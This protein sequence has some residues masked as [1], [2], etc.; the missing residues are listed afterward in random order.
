MIRK[1]ILSSFIFLFLISFTTVAQDIIKGKVNNYDGSEPIFG[2]SVTIKDQGIGTQT[3]ENGT[4]SFKYSGEYPFELC[5]CYLGFE[6]KTISISSTD[7]SI[8]VNLQEESESLDQVVVTASKVAESIVQAPVTIEKIGLAELRTTASVDAYGALYNLKGVQ[9]NTGSLTFTSINTRGFADMNNVRFVQLLDGMDSSAPGL[10]FPLGSNSGPADI[11]IASMELVPG[12]NSALYGANAF[13]GLIS[14]KTKNPFTYQGLSAYGKF[15]VTVQDAGG[16]NPLYDFGVRYAHAFNDKWAFKVNFG[17][18]TATDW[19]ANDESYHI[20][21]DK[22]SIKD[23]LLALPRNNPN[24]NAVNVYG[25]ELVATVDLDGDGTPETPINRTGINEEDIIDYDI[26]SYKFDAGIYY[27]IKDDMQLSYDYRYIQ[28]DGIYRHTTMYPLMNWE[29]QF[30]RLALESSSLN[31]LAFHSMEDAADSYAMLNT[32]AY[33]EGR[34]RSNAEWGADYGEAFRSG[35]SHDA[36]REYADSFMPAI[37]SDQYNQYLDETLSNTDFSTG[38]SKFDDTSTLSSIEGNY[39]FN[40]E[41]D[42]MELQIG[43]NYRL[44]QLNSSG[45]LFNDGPLGFDDNIDIDEYG[46]YAQAGKKIFNDRLH[47]RGSLRYDK[48]KNFDG[49]VTPRISAVFSFDEEKNHNLRMSYQTG[50]RNPA[51]QEA[52]INLDIKQAILLGGVKDNIDN[53][54]YKAGDAIVDGNTIFDNLYTIGSFM[55]YYGS[56]LAGAP[57]PSLLKK[58]NLQYLKQEKNQTFEIGYKSLIANKLFLDLNYYHTSYEDL[59]TRITTFSVD[60]M[61]AYAVY[62]NIEDKITSNGIGFGLD[63]LFGNGFRGGFNYTYTDFDADDAIANN[64]GFLPSFNTPEHRFNVSFSN[65]NLFDTGLG[66]NFKYRWYD[67]YI[68][69][70]PFGQGEIESA[71]VVDLAFNYTLTNLKSQV[72]LGATNLFQNEYNTV[73]GGPMVGSMYYVGWTFDDVFGK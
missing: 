9:A 51:T 67:D 44:Y 63:Y 57:D 46:F 36:A 33:V 16:T 23:D 71:G 11:D 6:T 28:S 25:D 52:Y 56:I 62:T 20:T 12:A 10:N 42:F 68:W 21:N 72:K 64:P 55:Q 59:V 18:L 34:R 37:G 43:G 26:N 48:N 24:Y 17:M 35:A 8:V 31:I 5:I 13:N 7:K 40:K 54:S 69:Q 27:R 47:L 65:S 22:V 53:Y 70:S 58:A 41:I 29:Q 73:Y 3:D 45:T 4:F 19:T 32:G 14:M 49:K 60:V 30:H 66:F 15:G 39:D 50:F 1:F 38:G 61:R 2:A